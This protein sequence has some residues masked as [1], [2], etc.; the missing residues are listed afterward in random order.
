[1]VQFKLKRIRKYLKN[2]HK[3]AKGLPTTQMKKMLKKRKKKK[4]NK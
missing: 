4:K 3:Q 1:M 2:A